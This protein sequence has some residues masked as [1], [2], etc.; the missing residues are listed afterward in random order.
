MAILYRRLKRIITKNGEKEEK[1]IAKCVLQST[2]S[3]QDVA[4][5][6]SH[7]STMTEGEV[8]LALQQLE[9]CLEAFI[10][11]GTKVKLDVWEHL[12]HR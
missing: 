11:N 7:N 6:I 4:E 8:Y 3:F 12:L 1:Y 9:D 5:Y 2:V 10:L